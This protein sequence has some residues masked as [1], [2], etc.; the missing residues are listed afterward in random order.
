MKWDYIIWDFDELLFNELEFDELWFDE[1]DF[2]ELWFDE[3]EFDE[4]WF[5]WNDRTSFPSSHL[6]NMA[7]RNIVYTGLGYRWY[8]MRNSVAY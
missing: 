4:L 1:L 5:R 6:S 3:L 2:D 7:E 8:S